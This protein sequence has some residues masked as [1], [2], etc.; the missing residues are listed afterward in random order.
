MNTTQLRVYRH[1]LREVNRQFTKV[2]K[3]KAW[4]AQLRLQWLDASRSS[5]ADDSD[6]KAAQ[7][8]LTYLSNNRQYK[9]LLAEFNPKMSE[10]DR[11][12][13]TARRVG[14]E[15]PKLYDARSSPSS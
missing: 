12:E 14:L 4:S 8:V 3:N 15:A 7:S 11:I 2:N 9:E 6:L 13:K 10:G 5:G 1:L